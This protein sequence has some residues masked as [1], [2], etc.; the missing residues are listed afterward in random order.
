MINDVNAQASVTPAATTNGLSGPQGGSQGLSYTLSPSYAG[1]GIEPSNLFAFTGTTSPNQMTMNL[2][3]NLAN[4]TGQPPHMRVGGNTGDTALYN[5]S[6]TGYYFQPNPETTGPTDVAYY[7]PN[8]FKVI[9]YLPKN[10]P[11]TYGLPMAYQG[12][13]ASQMLLEIAN[14]VVDA[15]TNIQ[16]F[17]LEVGNEP[18]LYVQNKF[19]PAGWGASQYGTEWSTAVLAVWQQVLQPK[20][21]TKSFFE[22]A[23][24]ATTAANHGYRIENLVTT[25]VATATDNGLY[26]GGWNQ[27]DYYYYVNVSN[28]KLT[29][30]ELMNLG[31]TAGQ[32]TEWTSQADQAATTGKPY[33]LREMGSVGPEGLSGISDT[34]GNAL[35]T[36]NFFLFASTVGVQSVQMHM[37]QDSYGSPW[38]PVVMADGTQP[39]VRPA[40]SAWAAMAQLNGAGCQ[41]QIAPLTINNIPNGYTN[42]LG[43]YA[44]Y[45]AGNLQ[46]VVLINTQVAYSSQ[47][48]NINTQQVSFSMPTNMAG[49]TFYISLLTAPGADAL[50]NTQ[51]N[52][53]DY[54][55]NGDGS[56]KKVNTQTQTAV[57]GSDGTLTLTVR[58]SQALVA[59]LGSQIGS[60]NNKPNSKA[61][62]NFSTVNSTGTGSGF[63]ATSGFASH[64]PLSLGAIIGIAAGGGSALLILLGLIIFCC[65]RRARRRRAAKMNDSAAALLPPAY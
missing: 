47:G 17:S 29:L 63:K 10:T 60:T 52:G 4:Y 53:Y 36:F 49:K 23:C 26:V 37:L 59:N 61:C 2:L 39:Y 38:Q 15:F 13:N 44:A 14:G 28:Y 5:S 45:D 7:G 65:V 33:Y 58:D 12:P 31:S 20:G 55:Q 46:S 62:K 40:Y 8:F 50:N 9:N 34:F 18:D 19:R 32:F 27:H 43:A 3:Q 22:A 30:S 16:L 1:M 64:L 41:T 56:A 54:A 25:G 42:R 21:V 48:Q 11:I 35:W 6:Y 24:S 57:V 51:W